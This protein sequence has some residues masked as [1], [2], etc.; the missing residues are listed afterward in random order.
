MRACVEDLRRHG[1]LVVCDGEVDPYLEMGEIHR[2]VFASGGPAVYYPQVKGSTFPAVSNLFGTIDRARFIFRDRWEGIQRLIELQGDASRLLRQPTRYAM[3]PWHASSMLPRTTR[4]GAVM[5]QQTSISQLPAIQNW[6]DDGGPFVL[7]PQ[8]YSEDPECSGL[9]RSNLGMYRIQLSGNEYRLDNEVGL[10]YQLHRGIGI[11]HT[12]ATELDIPFR[13]NVFVGGAAAMT[14]AAV[15]PLPEGMSELTFAGGLAGHRIPMIRQV[16]GPAIYADADFC[17]TGVVDRDRLLP[18]GPF[19]DH[20]GYYS[21]AHPF[22]VMRVE[23]VLHR[24]DAVWPFTVVGRPP[25]EDTVFGEMIHELT[26]P[27]IPTVVPGVR[28]VHAVDAAGVHPLMLAIGSERYAPFLED[29]KPR[30]LLT[31]ANAILG[32]GQMSL[33]KY[34]MIV[35]HHDNPELDVRDIPGFLGHLLE[36]VDWRRDL[37]FHTCTTIDTL[38]Y[39]GSGLNDGSKVVIAATGCARRS[40]AT[41]LDSGTIVGERFH[42]PR[43]CMPG[44]VAVEPVTGTAG[45]GDQREFCQT[46]RLAGRDGEFP[47]I[48]LVDDSDMVARTLENFL[49]VTF[50]RSDPAPD[51]DGIDSFERDKHWGCN[52]ALVIDARQKPHH[53]PVLTSDPAT[54]ERVDARA[55][56]GGDLGKYL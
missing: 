28:A 32:Q 44:V 27:I 40:L 21:L 45:A 52:G 12:R 34:L 39:S 23:R 30:E 41:E 35:A 17:I 2:R 36:R 10:H 3:A 33:A 48:V 43:I 19:G 50:T 25:Q 1:H 38:D 4:R 6:P 56:R 24:R 15:M 16:T 46:A 37:H 49:W 51:I 22:P 14:L 42:K 18:E 26:G 13:V 9:H 54:A 47:L 20:L 29:A 31:Q 7:L 55:A 11:H 53:A 5:A 8:V